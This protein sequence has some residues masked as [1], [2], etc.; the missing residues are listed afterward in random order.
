[1][2]FSPR[3]VDFAPGKTLALTGVSAVWPKLFPIGRCPTLYPGI[4]HNS[5]HPQE[6]P[7]A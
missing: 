4:A 7:H 5:A 1:M 2:L 3:L 6:A